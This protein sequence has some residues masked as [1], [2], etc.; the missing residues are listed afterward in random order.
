M[1]VEVAVLGSPSLSSPHGLC[2]CKAILN[3]N[4]NLL[5]VTVQARSEEGGGAGLSRWVGLS[6][7]S[8]SSSW[9]FDLFSVVTVPHGCWE[10]KLRSMQVA[11]HWWGPHLLNFVVLAVADGLW[12]LYGSQRRDELLV[13]S[14]SPLFPIP[15]KPCGFYRCKAPWLL[16]L[17]WCRHAVHGGTR[18]AWP[19]WHRHRQCPQTQILPRRKQVGHVIHT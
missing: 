19:L 8:G 5:Y 18:L 17:Q 4:L 3:L 2:G 11:W 9:S 6:F 16:L 13:C 15:N 1:K 7:D 10:S 12:G 14:R